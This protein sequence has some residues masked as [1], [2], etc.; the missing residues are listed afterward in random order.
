[1]HASNATDRTKPSR[2]SDAAERIL[3]EAMRL[4][5]EKGY[6]RTSVPEIQAAAGLTPGSGALYK[7][8]PSKEAVLRAGVERFIAVSEEQRAAFRT[9]DLPPADALVWVARRMLDVIAATRDEH[10]IVWREI[11]QFPALQ[12][13]VRREVMQSTYRALAAWLEEQARTG[14]IRAHDSDAVAAVLIGS[15]TMF[16]IF[17]ALWGEKTV[18]IDDERFVRAW[19]DLVVAGLGLDAPPS[20]SRAA[21]TGAPA[22]KRRA[23]GL[24]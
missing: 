16:R 2:R 15:L 11:E 7:H 21:R 3:R 24:G 9:L 14:A 6:E 5:A 12:A 13:A 1:M 23:G 18:P 4:F 20:G 10:R 22:K 8:Y 19:S 17:E